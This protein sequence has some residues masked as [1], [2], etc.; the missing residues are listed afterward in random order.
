M[1]I[2]ETTMKHFERL[3]HSAAELGAAFRS[4]REAQ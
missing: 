4:L 2:E 3:N 1:A